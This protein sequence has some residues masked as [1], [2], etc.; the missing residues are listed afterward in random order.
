[1]GIPDEL[2][3][4]MP[5]AYVH[6]THCLEHAPHVCAC[7]RAPSCAWHVCMACMRRYVHFTN[8]LVDALLLLAPYALYPTRGLL[9]I[10]RT[11]HGLMA[12]DGT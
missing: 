1:M 9:A 11:R 3:A 8:C 7:T 12:P 10:P 4:R 6:L 5:L 2:A